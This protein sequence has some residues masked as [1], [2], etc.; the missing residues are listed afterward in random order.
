MR[1]QCVWAVFWNFRIPT[2]RAR[3]SRFS[4]PL[5]CVRRCVRGA[6]RH[7]LSRM[8][9]Q[10]LCS[11]CCSLRVRAVPPIRAHAN[12]VS[13]VERV[14]QR[15]TSCFWGRQNTVPRTPSFSLTAFALILQLMT[16]TCSP[17]AI[18]TVLCTRRP[19]TVSNPHPSMFMYHWNEFCA[20]LNRQPHLIICASQEN[21]QHLFS[22]TPLPREPL[23]TFHSL[24][25]ML[26]LLLPPPYC[27]LLL[28]LPCLHRCIQRA[29]LQIVCGRSRMLSTSLP[30]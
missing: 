23:T 7:S 17:M 2:P 16:E 25:W 12:R 6:P 24:L 13:R 22:S 15:A 14:S 29:L 11:D 4:K 20:V 3:V 10:L 19:L 30:S 1:E 27:P 9:A 26:P 21:H 5:C 28:C 8:A 18:A